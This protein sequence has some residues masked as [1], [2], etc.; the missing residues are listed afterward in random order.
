MG[1][2]GGTLH[3]LLV[4][5]LLPPASGRGRCRWWPRTEAEHAHRGGTGFAEFL[6]RQQTTN[7]R[8]ITMGNKSM[9]SISRDRSG[10]S[11]NRLSLLL[12][13]KLHRG[14]PAGSCDSRGR[15]Q[16]SDTRALPCI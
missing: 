3:R 6:S 10:V 8:L 14:R 11:R 9:R 4:V 2:T 16:P 13:A 1:M 15:C 5:R 7:R 12:A